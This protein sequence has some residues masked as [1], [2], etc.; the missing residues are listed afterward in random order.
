MD[1]LTFMAST[2]AGML[3]IGT[4]YAVLADWFERR[5]K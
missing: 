4:I 5:S 1:I 2:A 3:L